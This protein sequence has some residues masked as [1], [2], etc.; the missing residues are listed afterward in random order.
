VA[1]SYQTILDSIDAA[2]ASGAAAPLTISAGDRNLTYRN[3]DQLLAARK[4]YAGLA[5][6]AATRAASGRGFGISYI[7]NGDGR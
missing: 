3:M 7:K 6:A 5:A 2:I 4:Y 1:T